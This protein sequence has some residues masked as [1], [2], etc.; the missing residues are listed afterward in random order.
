MKIIK[1]IHFN[2]EVKVFETRPKNLFSML[3]ESAE[4][5]ADNEAL[6]M[7]GSRLTYKEMKDKVEQIA[8]NLQKSMCVKKGD[9]VALLLG[10]SIEFSLL[11]FAVAKLG[12]IA[13]P[14]NTRLKEIELSYMLRQSGS[15]LLFVD[16][17]FL[18]KVESM[19]DEDSISTVQYFFLVG[20][21]TP[22]RKDYL[23]YE[24][25]EQ[26]ST[27]EDV[28][29]AEDDPLFIMY[30]S[31]TTGLPKGAVG[32]HIS[33][34]H[35][36][37]N[38]QMVLNTN[39]EAKTLIAVPLFHV[40]GLIGQLFHMVRVG[41]TSVIMK[42]FQTE[43]FITLTAGEQV[44]FL[45]NV[46]TI[47]IMMM[48]HHN[49]AL[50]NF[51]NVNLIA[52]GGAP[53]SSET[54]YKLK[55]YF[56]NA[57]LH[58]AYGATETSSPA[59]I[60][61]RIYDEAKM[62]SVGLPVPV[63]DLIVVN[64]EDEPCLP[65]EAGELLIK[66]PMVVEGYWDNKSANQ[67]SFWNGYWRSGDL[68]KMDVD[69]FVYIVDR[70]KDL[71]NRGGEKIFCI[72]VENVLYNHPKVLEAAVVGIPDDLFGEVVKAVIVPKDGEILDEE[73]IR[74][75]VA[76][77]LANYK[78]PKLIEFAS[79]LPRNPGGKILKNVLRNL[80]TKVNES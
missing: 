80:Q 77:R 56:P 33:A 55:K 57:R 32:S 73:E 12:A 50:Y 66:G 72:E 67:A 28:F 1:E 20:N 61:P 76:A 51:S 52:Y 63:G 71:I 18:P 8:G 38:Y 14:L 4:K 29:V 5:Y 36:S 44:S 22:K 64:D 68:A 74:E 23:P 17:E 79:E 25:L 60:M 35:S 42:R 53:M 37:M 45:F 24:I 9:R 69:G 58:N 27:F 6:V 78:V 41:G 3:E 70:K 46:P 2:R 15:R 11:V 47:Y 59:T 40:T 31:G 21:G 7:N 49:F 34:I 48:S 10:N 16:D 19:R 75:F 62:D 54:I 30:T 13:V 43:E 26:T 39:H 65:G